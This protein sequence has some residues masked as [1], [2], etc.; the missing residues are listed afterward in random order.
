MQQDDEGNDPH[1]GGDDAADIQS[2]VRITDERLELVKRRA[3]S[4]ICGRTSCK[5]W[6]HA[7]DTSST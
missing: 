6:D 3:E 1:D 5:A 2:D 4:V 7:W